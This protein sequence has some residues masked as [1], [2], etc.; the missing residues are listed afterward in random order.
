[1]FAKIEGGVLADPGLI[2][3]LIATYYPSIRWI[4]KGKSLK[5]TLPKS[6]EPIQI[7]NVALLHPDC[8]YSIKLKTNHLDIT[9][10]KSRSRS[11]RM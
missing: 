5:T 8:R 11:I 6:S 7:Y 1:M 2:L 9:S 3:I 4:Y 10:Y